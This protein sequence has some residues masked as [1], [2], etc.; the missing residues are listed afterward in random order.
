MICTLCCSG[1]KADTRQN[2]ANNKLAAD[3]SRASAKIASSSKQDFGKLKRKL[4][5]KTTSKKR[6]IRVVSRRL[7]SLRS[8]SLAWTRQSVKT[9]IRR[10]QSHGRV[11]CSMSQK[12]RQTKSLHEST[13]KSILTT[14]TGTN[15]NC[16][17]EPQVSARSADSV[18]SHVTEVRCVSEPVTSDASVDSG[19]SADGD[20]ESVSKDH[21]DCQP[22]MID[23]QDCQRGMIDHQ[24]CQPGMIDHQDCQRGMIDNQDCQPGMIDNQDCQRGMIDNQDCQPGMIDNQDSQRVITDHY[25]SWPV[26]SDDFTNNSLAVAGDPASDVTKEPVMRDHCIVSEPIMSAE[27]VD[28]TA[29]AVQE[30]DVNLTEEVRSCQ[31]PVGDVT[32]E[33]VVDLAAAAETRDVLSML[34]T[35]LSSSPSSCQVSSANCFAAVYI[36]Q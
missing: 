11:C 8:M 14:S 5:T 15:T 23:H 4:V 34:S 36:A 20:V 10:C 9:R 29:S 27:C 33:R 1:T 30:V 32:A 24:D 22:G 7:M 2:F 12:C 13:A 6:Q 17:T 26:M 25:D 19:T 28:N 3:Q 18:D 16:A 21:Q 35:V 31:Q